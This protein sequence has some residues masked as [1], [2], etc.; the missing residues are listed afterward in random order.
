MET[1]VTILLSLS[2]LPFSIRSTNCQGWQGWV[3]IVT[4]W[5]VGGWGFPK[6]QPRQNCGQ[7]GYLRSSRAAEA[8]ESRGTVVYASAGLA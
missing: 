7:D 3:M 4:W 6:F 2:G 5:L 1:F 8:Q